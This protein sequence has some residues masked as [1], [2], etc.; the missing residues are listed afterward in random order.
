MS[1]RL[2]KNI[3]L[4]SL[5]TITF[6]SFILFSFAE[7]TNVIEFNQY[8][9]VDLKKAIDIA[10]NQNRTLLQEYEDNKIYKL[11]VKTEVTNFLPVFQA[12]ND[13]KYNSNV[14]RRLLYSSLSPSRSIIRSQNETVV[15]VSQP[16]SDLYK[17]SLNY[18]IAK[19]NYNVSMLN[20]TLQKETVIDDVSGLYFDILKQIRTIK[21]NK[22]NVLS[23]E[24]YYKIAKDRFD[25]GEAL[26]SD[27]LKIQVEVDNAKHDLYVE[28]NKL[29]LLLTKFKN[30]LGVDLEQDINIVENFKEDDIASKSLEELGLIALE[31]RPD[32]KQQ[33]RN[34]T[35]ARLN[36]K[37]SWAEYIPSV[38][39]SV[40]YVHDYG[41]NFSV[42]DNVLLWVSA[43]YD[44]WKW[45]QRY[46]GVKQQKS[47]I[48]KTELALKDYE[49]QIIIDVQDQLNTVNEAK[50]LIDVSRNTVKYSEE[51]LRITK[52]RF[53][54]G[55]ALAIDLLNDQSNLL[56]S[57][58]QLASSELDYQKSLVTL[59]KTLGILAPEQ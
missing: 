32:L 49:N 22:E 55:L 10:L 24:G 19:E 59:K 21:Y 35:I 23:L 38:N 17:T 2:I 11:K 9:N 54:V 36:K 7:E 18:R 20:T 28:E 31:N 53:E 27:Y 57:Q 41:S 52:N 8:S 56:N 5:L 30:A 39:F 3:I 16:I 58:V 50:N 46:Y 15:G 6:N 47:E 26:A 4:I 45:N 40:S 34:V 42:K 25:H 13:Y 14:N 1:K 44:F 48:T 29:Q 43:S 37:L 51:S 12:S 33:E